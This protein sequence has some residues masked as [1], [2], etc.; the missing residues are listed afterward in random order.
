M[1]NSLVNK[2]YDSSKTIYN[3]IKHDKS[4]G[5]ET[6]RFSC[7]NGWFQ[8]LMKMTTKIEKLNEDFKNLNCNIQIVSIKE[9]DGNLQ[10]V[11]EFM[12]KKIFY[13]FYISENIDQKTIAYIK[14]HNFTYFLQ[15]MLKKNYNFFLKIINKLIGKINK[16]YQKS[17]KRVT[18]KKMNI[19]WLKAN[20]IINETIMKCF[21]TC[22][23]CGI[24]NSDDNPLINT[25]NG[26]RRICATCNRRR[27]YGN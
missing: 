20:S 11:F 17:F 18:Y 14:K 16:V 1:D 27:K 3:H 21:N 9:K 15:Y 22:E 25:T 19:Y 24:S 5:C 8:P 23:I 4:A 26:T 13:P 12:D 10:V 2:L 6:R 7:G